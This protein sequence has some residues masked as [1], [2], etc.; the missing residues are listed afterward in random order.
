MRTVAHVTDV[1]CKFAAWIKSNTD[2]LQLNIEDREMARVLSI[3]HG[4][5]H[6]WT[7]EYLYGILHDTTRLGHWN[8]EVSRR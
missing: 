5:S 2:R 1:G 8:G 6:S 7:C 4:K 3:L